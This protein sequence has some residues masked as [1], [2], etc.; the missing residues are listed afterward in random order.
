[1]ARA[2]DAELATASPRVTA[3]KRD[4]RLT[5]MP[6]LTISSVIEVARD[7]TIELRDALHRL[8][9]QL[10]RSATPLTQDQLRRLLHSAAITVLIARDDSRRIVGTLTLAILL[11]PTGTRAW[12]E[13]VVVDE[14]ARGQGVGEALTSA[15]LEIARSKGA[16]TVDLTSSPSRDAANRLYLR[17]G[18][19]RRETNVYRYAL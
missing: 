12:I 7:P 11:I 6:S 17:M 3:L 14:A 5:R 16:R 10:S 13:D 1:L 19:E 9:P 15:A 4:L 18:F 8:V 2:F